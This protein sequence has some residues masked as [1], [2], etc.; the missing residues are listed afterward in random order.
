MK[1]LIIPSWYP[2][3]ENRTQGIFFLKQAELLARHHDVRVLIGKEE[4]VGYRKAPG[5]LSSLLRA[6]YGTCDF[7]LDELPAVKLYQFSYD[8]FVFLS[9]KRRF[10]RIAAIYRKF[11]SDRVATAWR[12][13]L[14]HAHDPFYGGLAA[15]Q[16]LKS[17]NIPFV[18]TSHT[19][20]QPGKWKADQTEVLRR[21]FS[22]AARVL[23][24]SNFDRDNLAIGFGS[25]IVPVT[26][27]N[28][29]DDDVLYNSI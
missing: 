18:I 26:V 24:V 29:I 20:F 11:F 28:Y 10:E 14:V 1:I 5:K 4:A 22:S 27:G 8:D 16:I 12:P 15:M 23:T 19:P 17:Y 21:I 9:R 7:F 6:S 3:R 13:D 2:H 25:S